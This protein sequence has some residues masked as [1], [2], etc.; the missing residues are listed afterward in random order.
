MQQFKVTGMTCAACSARVEKAVKSVDGVTDCAVSLLTDSMNVEGGNADAIISA[1][2]YAGYGASLKNDPKKTEDGLGLHDEDDLFKDTETPKLKKRLWTSAV[3]LA[4]L[5]YI[6]MGHIMWG[7]PMPAFFSGNAIALSLAQL[8]LTIAV[9]FINRAFFINGFKAIF[10]F[11]P[12]MDSLVAL[13]SS[14]AFIYSLYNV[15]LMT[16][17]DSVEAMHLLHGLYFESAA[18][19]LTLITVGKMLEARSK[20]RT[21]NALKSLVK[22]SPKTARIVIDGVE[23]VVPAAEVKVGDTFA[24]RAGDSIP[25]DGVVVEGHSAV[26]ESALTGESIPVEKQKGSKVSAA[27]VNTSGYMLCTA[28]RVGSDTALSNIIKMVTDAATSKAPIAKVADKVSGVFVPVVV[29]IALITFIAWMLLGNG[30]G[31][32]LARAISVL[33]I[34]CPCALGLAT[35]V[36][37]MV[38]N[39]VGAKNGI[40]FKTAASLESAGRITNVVLD[41][42]GTVTEGKPKVT[43]LN[44]ADGLSLDEFLTVTASAEAL[45]EHPLAKAVVLKATENNIKLRAVDN[46]ETLAGNGLS[47]EIDGQRLFG[48]SLKFIQSKLKLSEQTVLL[49]ENIAKKGE[50]PILFSLNGK[51]LGLIAIADQP[52]ADSQKAVSELKQMGVSVAML[53]GDNEITARAV[54]QKVGIDKVYAGVLPDGKQEIVLE[55]KKQ[56]KVAMVGDGIN[57]AVALTSADLGVAI[58]TGTDIAIDSADVVLMKSSLTDVVAAI[59]LGRATLRNIRENLFWAFVYNCI[60]IPLAAGVFS[61]LLGWDLNPMFGALAMSLSSFCVVTNALRLNFKKIYN[62]DDKTDKEIFKMGKTV[63]IEGMMC[64]HCEAHVKKAIEAV[65]GVELANVSHENGTAVVTFK[66]DVSNEAL[67][68]AVESEGYKVLEII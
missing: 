24:V 17:V 8:L 47:A 11:S 23:K 14:A 13:G 61:H 54:A 40:L 36:A 18:M 6:S 68:N 25:V 4:L 19:I 31:Y 58:G 7:W 48:G 62:K 5:M 21:T 30:V 52:K 63:K 20:G 37:I 35:P 9:I 1:V 32:S 43:E 44:P 3:F 38:G 41:K 27:T 42:T 57:D 53:T 12:N 26:D 10:K 15:F 50:T 59:R 16:A 33:V 39:G 45:S 51:Y 28:Q 64:R 55:L 56:G 60:G 67:K 65:A 34:S 49:A 2:R 29:G 22:L 66:S 46:F